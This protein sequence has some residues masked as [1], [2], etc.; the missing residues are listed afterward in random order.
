VLRHGARGASL[1]FGRSRWSLSRLLAGWL[2][3]RGPT[4]RIN[5]DSAEGLQAGQSP[6]KFKDI[7]LG[8]VKTLTLAPDHKRV[9]VTV[10]TIRQASPL[11]TNETIFWV[12]KPRLFAGSLSGLGTLLSG[13]YIGMLPGEGA[14]GAKR[15]FVGREVP[16]VLEQDVP[17]RTFL[18][19]TKRL[20]S[21]TLGSPI[22]FRD[23]SVGEVLGWD[24]GDMA[25]SVTIHAFVRAPFDQ[26]VRD[27]SRFW[28]ASGVSVKLGG[29]G[30][31]LQVES[32]RA[33]LLGGITFDTPGSRD[34]SEVSQANHEFPLFANHEDAQEASYTRKIPF[35]AYFPG[36]VR[37]LA[38]GNDVLLHGL[39]VGEVLDVR[40]TYDP[41][42]NTIVAPVRFEVQ[43]E[44]LV[45][46]GKQ[47]YRNPHDAIEELIRQGLRASLESGNLLTGQMLVGL[48]FDPNAP[49]AKLAMEGTDFV[50]PTGTGD[51]LG[52]IQAAAGELL[53]KVNT[54]PFDTIGRSL[55]DLSQRM[56]ELA[57][58]PELK[59][60]MTSLAATMT[61]AQ[62]AVQKLN[63]GVGPAA[64]RLPDIAAGLQKTLTE[65]NQTMLSFQTGY[66]D[67]TAFH[68]DMDRL[69]TSL[70]DAVRSIRALADLL[71][72][73]P[74]ALIRGRPG[75]SIE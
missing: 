67:N 27:D 70:N 15:D 37:G 29:A 11:L 5:F 4:I 52:G 44:R 46:I 10:A 18:L 14:G 61:G 24:L 47:V 20:G 65:A 34:K 28:N 40:L 38:P 22:F 17:G 2:G 25:E 74:E 21:V 64:K 59:Q 8:T 75:G 51:G 12:V 39:K 9:T 73:N 68:R 16:P 41:V 30:V 54:I 1:S 55:G 57:D 6:L 63:D 23:L 33:I 45:G 56:S 43:P 13:S 72:R 42:K 48:D 7:T 62:D 36:S 53:R 58:G 19:K 71:A 49:P 69:F 26:Y 66:G 35:V 3:T 31:E 32:L 60:T 50:F